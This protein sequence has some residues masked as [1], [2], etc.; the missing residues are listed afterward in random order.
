MERR[1]YHL[2]KEG[3]NKHKTH[4]QLTSCVVENTQLCPSL[5]TGLWGLSNAPSLFDFVDGFLNVC[6]V[7]QNTFL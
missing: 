6:G 3:D 5:S 7:E 4:F 2:S 1:L